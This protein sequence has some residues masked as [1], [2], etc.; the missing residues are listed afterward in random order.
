MIRRLSVR[1]F[2]S[3]V[4]QTV[5]LGRLNVFIGANGAGKSVLLEAIGVLGAAADGR[6]DDTALL[7]RGVRPGVPELYKNAFRRPA[8]P[9]VIGL[10][11]ESNSAPSAT[12]QIG[13]DNPIGRGGAP[14]RFN[15]ERVAHGQQDF[16]TR[17]PRGANLRSSRGRKQSFKPRD[18]ARGIADTPSPFGPLPESAT[19]LLEELRGFVIYDPQTPVL[20]GISQESAPLDP[21]GINGS[22]LAEAV[23][24]LL[25]E[26][27]RTFGQMSLDDLRKL[28]DWASELGVDKPSADLISPSLPAAKLI[29]RF[30]DRHMKADRN[31]LSAYDASEGALFVL[32]ALVILYHSR[33]PQ[34]CAVDNIDHALHPRLARRLVETLATG[35]K[36]TQRQV[37]LTTH[38]PLVLDA[39]DLRDDDIRLFTVDRND[40][41]HTLIRRLPFSEML[42][43]AIESDLTLS[44]LW[45][46]GLIGAVPNIL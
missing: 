23:N 43:Q 2:K 29:V 39:L 22:R 19:E 33:A 3:I 7:R 41:G 6:V 16:I 31:R 32:F 26:E 17:S 37:L 25:D 34:I 10:T 28:V 30:T 15:S 40:L 38:N 1:G 42:E 5:E 45:V 44:Q 11:A 24:E 8:V 21:I 4:N 14:W 27:S 13:L 9:R 46:R 12:Y 35:L 20:R 18:P 36:G